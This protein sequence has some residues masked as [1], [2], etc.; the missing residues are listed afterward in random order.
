MQADAR[1]RAER[2]ASEPFLAVGARS[3]TFGGTRQSFREIW[4]S[5]ELLGLLVRREVK[6]RYKNSSLGVVWS[7]F[8]PLVQ[9]LIYYFAIGQILGAA[10]FIPDFAIF[11]FIGLTVW[12]LFSEIVSGSTTALLTN[13]GLV[14]KV[15]LPRE[16][17]PLSSVGG[18][19][20]NF[21]VQLVVL[22]AAIALLSTFPFD[23]RLLLALAEDPRASV[24]A[25]SQRLGLASYEVLYAIAGALPAAVL[26]AN[27]GPEAGPRLLALDADLIEVFC[28]CPPD[29]V[30][31]RFA[32][33]A[34]TR[35]PGHVDHQIAPEM[36]A[37]RPPGSEPL[38]L[39]GP[40]LE[41]DTSRPVD[42]AEIATWV[43]ARLPSA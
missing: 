13:A 32:A 12:S 19:L 2:I 43:G 29:E 7:L 40:I 15:Y 8:R 16:I 22:L 17:F 10:R 25:L 14:K 9:L 5:R 1:S 35:H 26:D 33:R 18:A 27:L 6:A 21:A 20:F 39:G 34:P 31:R 4:E 30:E 42:V 3:S 37:A 41:V 36:K 38:R 11:V 23:A 24:M 28:R